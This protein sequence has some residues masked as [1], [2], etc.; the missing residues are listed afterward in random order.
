[1]RRRHALPAIAASGLCPLGALAQPG[2]PSASDKAA[3]REHTARLAAHNAALVERA[4]RALGAADAAGYRDTLAF[5]H[6]LREF[7]EPERRTT[8][9]L[10]AWAALARLRDPLEGAR[11]TP[12]RVIAS[13]HV[14]AVVGVL[15][16]RH[17][18][19]IEGTAPSM[20]PVATHMLYVAFV[21]EGLIRDT[22]IY[23]GT[24]ELVLQARGRAQ[25]VPVPTA[26]SVHYLPPATKVQRAHLQAMQAEGLFAVRARLAGLAGDA[27]AHALAQAPI[28]RSAVAP[29][30]AQAVSRMMQA[31]PDLGI[32]LD[33][34]VVANGQA[35]AL[36]TVRGSL[37]SQVGSLPAPGRRFEV[38]GALVYAL[39]PEGVDSVEVFLDRGPVVQQL[40][41]E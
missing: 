28:R 16:G 32:R 10:E 33:E 11:I 25:S 2:T 9:R 39:T 7:R 18:K 35:L 22:L 41:G 21:R 12:Q 34:L 3:L 27:A 17:V 5:N 20:R 8:G 15:D 23:W 4:V 1:M 26:A 37:S 36:V 14:A 19:P 38:K 13:R 30:A 40:G 29:T 6:G 31:T 24:D